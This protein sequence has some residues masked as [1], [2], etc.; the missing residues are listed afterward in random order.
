MAL[1]VLACKVH[2]GAEGIGVGRWRKGES[3]PAIAR[4]LEQRNK[5]CIYEILVLR[6]EIAPTVRKRS[7][8]Q[9]LGLES[10]ITALQISYARMYS[11]QPENCEYYEIECR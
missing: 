11:E 4:A 2:R 6:G 9:S 1:G 8:A 5:T 7:G 10:A 3:I